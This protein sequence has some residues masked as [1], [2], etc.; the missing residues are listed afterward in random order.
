MTEM[1]KLGKIV[2]ALDKH[3]ARDI[4]AIDVRGLSDVTDYFVFATGG[5]T[6]QVKAL[7]DYVETDLKNGEI[8]PDRIEG[9]ATS[10]WIL[11]DYGSVV[12]HLFLPEAREFYDIERLWK[13]GTPV[14]ITE[15]LVK[16]E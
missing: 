12:I 16:E 4:V 13:D 15:Y 7:C 10:R 2:H 9:Y 5:S 1:E 6:T 3:L 8:A 11:M 14:D